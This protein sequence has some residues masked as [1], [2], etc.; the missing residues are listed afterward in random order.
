M[1]DAVD[2]AAVRPTGST[3]LRTAAGFAG[4]GVFWTTL[5]IVAP[6]VQSTFGL[7]DA[8]WGTLQAATLLCGMT[9]M[10]LSGRLGARHGPFVLMRTGLLALMLA[11]AG[12]AIAPSLGLF[13]ACMF[14]AGFASAPIEIGINAAAV[15]VD[16][17]YHRRVLG[18]L[19]AMFSAASLVWGLVLAAFVQLGGG[20]TDL[21]LATAAIVLVLAIVLPPNRPKDVPP[22][23]DEPVSVG[24]LR[25]L[26]R[27]P[28]LVPLAIVCMTA[29]V[30][31]GAIGLWS[32]L[33]LSED[34]RA[35]AFVA[36]AGF[37]VFQAT[38]MAGRLVLPQMQ[39]IASNRTI[40][41]VTGIGLVA[42]TGLAL[43][44][45]TV[46]VTIAGFFVCGVCT[47]VMFPTVMNEAGVLAPGEIAVSTAAI[48]AVGYIGLV[49]GPF[50]IGALATAYSLRAALAI[51]ALCGAAVVLCARGIPAAPSSTEVP[52]GPA[53]ADTGD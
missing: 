50:V 41:A 23:D 43:A 12:A 6:S 8:G 10:G 45:T 21:L 44:T 48:S 32:F 2:A 28:R 29:F 35:P 46:G 7:D 37:A 33:Y 4:F 47:S 22:P 26:R 20:R 52:S 17:A 13:I 5:G 40:L 51:V 9:V 49:L 36:G 27:R 11:A 14:L 19:H 30:A 53:T 3:V 16:L 1:T 34:L 24:A 18:P 25:A 39:A 15:T 42:G 31:E 38:M